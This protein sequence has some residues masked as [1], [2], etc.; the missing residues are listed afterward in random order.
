VVDELSS[1]AGHLGVRAIQF[2]ARVSAELR[3]VAGRTTVPAIK[4]LLLAVFTGCLLLFLSSSVSSTPEGGLKIQTGVPS[5]W[6]LFEKNPGAT[7]FQIA[8]FSW[9]WAIALLGALACCL[10]GLIRKIETGGRLTR[11]E[12][13]FSKGFALWGWVMIFALAINS[14][15]ILLLS[16]AINSKP[17]SSRSPGVPGPPIIRS[18]PVGDPMKK[19]ER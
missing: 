5:P 15:Q 17:P 3:S 10:H 18:A 13:F 12:R 9:S 8:L 11:L 7:R 6:F 2:R 16:F 4:V 1:G 19:T 14:F